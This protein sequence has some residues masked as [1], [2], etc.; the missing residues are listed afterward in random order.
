MHEEG[1]PLRGGA[2]AALEASHKRRRHK[3]PQSF[4]LTFSQCRLLTILH[5]HLQKCLFRLNLATA[6]PKNF[7]EPSM[8]KHKKAEE[9]HLDEWLLDEAVVTSCDEK[10]P[11]YPLLI[12]P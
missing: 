9:A 5:I 10:W 11:P 2:E 3:G 6:S 4:F 12:Q 1:G 7:A 8:I